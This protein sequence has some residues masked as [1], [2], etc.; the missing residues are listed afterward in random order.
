MDV[1]LTCCNSAVSRYSHGSI[2]AAIIKKYAPH[3][4]IGSIRIIDEQQGNGSVYQ[5]VEAIEHCIGNNVKL[6]HMSIGS[7]CLGDF[8][9]L[10]RVTA[11]ALRNGCIIVS[12]LSNHNKFSF[13]ASFSGIIGVRSNSC[14]TGQEIMCSRHYGIDFE[15]TSIH[16]LNTKSGEPYVSARCNS[17]ASPVLTALVHQLCEE[18]PDLK[19]VQ[20]KEKLLKKCNYRINRKSPIV[21]FI[22]KFTIIGDS[23]KDSFVDTVAFD[24]RMK[25]SPYYNLIVFNPEKSEVHTYF[26]SLIKSEIN[27][28]SGLVYLGYLD[29]PTRAQL[30][31]AGIIVWDFSNI[32]PN[33]QS[34]PIQNNTGSIIVL[35]EGFED[36][37]LEFGSKLKAE[38]ETRGYPSIC[39]SNFPHSFLHGYIFACSEEFIYS[40]AEYYEFSCVILYDQPSIDVDWDVK[41]DLS[42]SSFELFEKC[43]KSRTYSNTFNSISQVVEE[44]ISQF[45]AEQ[46]L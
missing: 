22:D 9:N 8:R 11:K 1:N 4:E 13:P 40:C 6:I 16:S 32:L 5:L 18:T 41:I 37:P 45:S 23:P 12:S 14:L 20:V 29:E 35:L 10:A 21:D 30:T 38:F 39:I 43:G 33:E 46:S 17:F 28:L 24:E 42:Q 34:L 25:E 3:A 19:V 7:I 26:L 15:A 27:R 44:I 31:N 36:V 2:C